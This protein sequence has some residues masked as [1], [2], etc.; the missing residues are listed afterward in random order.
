VPQVKTVRLKLQAAAL[1]L[2]GS[3]A[4]LAA[5]AS[6]AA[7]AG[8][9][10]DISTPRYQVNH[11]MPPKPDKLR[12]FASVHTN[13]MPISFYLKVTIFRWPAVGAKA[14]VWTQCEESDSGGF[15]K[16]CVFTKHKGQLPAVG[17]TKVWDF[18][19]KCMPGKYYSEWHERDITNAGIPESLTVYFPS[20]APHKKSPDRKQSFQVTRADCAKR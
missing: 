2:A 6:P 8:T 7:A 1:A 12:L 11:N 10:V 19:G 3:A 18:Y 16:T 4:V 15:G 5:V 13:V 20:P 9:S 14:K 17:R